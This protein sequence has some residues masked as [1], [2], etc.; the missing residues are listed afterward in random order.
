MSNFKKLFALDNPVRLLYHKLRAITANIIYG[1]PSKGMVIIGVT[2]TNGKTTTS[3][4]IAKG[5]IASGKKVFMFTTVNIIIGDKEY[6]NDTKMTSPDAFLLQRLFKQAKNEGCEIAVIETASHG[7]KMSRVWGLDYDIAVLTNITQDHLDLHKT[8]KDYVNTK[9]RLFKE[10]ISFAR[11]PGIKKTAVINVGSEYS[12]LFTGETYDSVY[13]YG[14]GNKATLVAQDVRIED[15][16]TKFEIKLPGKTLTIET[17][18]KGDFNIENILAAIGVFLS[19]S[20]SSANIQKAIKSVTGVP[21]RMELVE[22]DLGADIIVDYAHTPDALE[23]V[24]TTLKEIG[25]NKIVTVFG[26][27]GDRDKTKRPIMGEIVAKY[28]DIVILTQD[29]DY[30]ENSEMIIKDVIPGIN[31]VEGNDFFIIPTRKEAIELGISSIGKGDVLLIAGKGD[32]H[33]MVTNNGP[34][35]WHDK[36]IIKQILKEIDDN[37]IIV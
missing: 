14:K 1:F 10:L 6:V 9:L 4:I 29:D 8:M 31:R 12:E 19:F 36:S 17:T 15:S 25:Y 24:L 32:E 5:L 11:K 20:I 7:I 27:T 37:K 23:K 22:N 35:E 16:V 13:L 28:S 26:A 21:G 33:V 18:L 30:T 34:I 3:N 2:G